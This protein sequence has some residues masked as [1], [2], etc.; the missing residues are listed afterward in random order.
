MNPS[1]D[2]TTTHKINLFCIHSDIM[3]TFLSIFRLL[4]YRFSVGLTQGIL[5]VYYHTY[6]G[7]DG[8]RNVKRFKSRVEVATYMGLFPQVRLTNE[9]RGLVYHTRI[10]KV[11]VTAVL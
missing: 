6:V 1:N 4:M 11:Y 9:R 5:N 8:T 3:L 2:Q 10:H 7:L